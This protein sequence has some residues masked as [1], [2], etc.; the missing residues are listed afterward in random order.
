MPRLNA[1]RPGQRAQVEGRQVDF[2][3][4][5]SRPGSRHHWALQSRLFA[6]DPWAIMRQT[7]QSECESTRR[8]EALATLEQAEGFY[9]MGTERG[10]EAAQPLALYYSYMNL[11][12]AFC[13]LKATRPTFDQARHGLGEGLRTGHRE[14]LDAF[15]SAHPT[16][17]AQANNLTSC[18]PR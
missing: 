2:S 13:L 14:L 18:L 4:W 10:A 17:V 12:K 3:F 16:S 6:L 5:P 11:A 8:P 15:L 7:I 1:A 9:F